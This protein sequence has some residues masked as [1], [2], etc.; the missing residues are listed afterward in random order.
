MPAGGIGIDEFADDVLAV[1]REAGVERAVYCGHSMG[2]A[3]GLKAAI[4]DPSIAAGVAMLDG[5]VLLP[6]PIRRQ[7]LETLVPALDGPRWLEALRGYLRAPPARPM[8]RPRSPRWPRTIGRSPRASTSSSARLA[9]AARRPHAWAM[10]ARWSDPRR[11]PGPPALLRPRVCP[12]RHPFAGPLSAVEPFR[13]LLAGVVMGGALGSFVLPLLVEGGPRARGE[14]G[15]ASP[16]LA[17]LHQPPAACR[18]YSSASNHPSED[19]TSRSGPT[20]HSS[21]PTMRR[22]FPVAA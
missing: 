20:F 6:E 13:A 19:L 21:H 9:T 18:S 17:C 8:C 7:S 2:G 15:A 1:C 16:P 5:A 14:G 11:L 22:G 4:L 3:V 12:R 10:T